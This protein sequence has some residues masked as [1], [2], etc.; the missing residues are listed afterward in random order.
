M[1]SEKIIEL[2][3]SAKRV[4]EHIIKFSSKGGAF[5]GS[6]MSCADILVYLYKCFLKI[7]SRNFKD[8]DRD[9]FFLSKGHAVPAQYG[10][11]IEIGWMNIDRL[12]N[13]LKTNDNIYWHP[14]ASVSGIEFHS[15]SLGHLLSIAVGI[16][17][18]CKQKKKR[19]KIVV[20]LGDGELN[21]GTIWES[22]LIAQATK[23]D[24]LIV[25]IDRNQIQ[26]NEKTEN[27]IP[28][29]PLSLK[30]E[31]FGCSVKIIDG[32]NFMDIDEA[33]T[34]VPFDKNRPSVIIADTVRG[35]GIISIESKI[36]KWFVDNNDY[37]TIQY[38]NELHLA[39]ELET[40][41]GI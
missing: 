33:L 37:E 10:V 7:D 4:R 34:N 17:I 38:L 13:H 26:A 40:E 25:I 2:H 1:N 18:D 15:G 9:Y 3:E 14:N 12:E 39:R 23:L 35:K 8:P 11:F 19:N 20:M 5:I 32:H 41:V 28:L 30:F 36:N 24:N 6:A 22:L 16:A 31:S 27:L 29:E 21:E